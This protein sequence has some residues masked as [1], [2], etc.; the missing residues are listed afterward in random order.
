LGVVLYEMATG[1]MPF[2]GESAAQVITSMMRDKPRRLDGSDPRLPPLL[3]EL[4]ASLL[5]KDPAERPQSAAEVRDTLDRLA[6]RHDSE[7]EALPSAVPRRSWQPAIATAGVDRRRFRSWAIAGAALVAAVVAAGLLGRSLADRAHAIPAV[8][9]LPV[10]SFG[11]EPDYFV[12]GTT[13]GLIGALGRFEGLRV[14]SRQSAMHYKG[15]KMRLPEIADELGVDY[16][17]E[18]SVA[19]D[20]ERLRLQ[21][22]IVRAQ[23]E[24]QVWSQAFE[25]PGSG[26]LA[27]HNEVATAVARALRARVS[28][29][30]EVRM[31]AAREVDPA[32]Y[33]AYL[34]GRQLLEQLR[35]E[36]VRKARE[37]FEEAIRI[38][39]KFALAHSGL[40]DVHWMLAQFFE[41]P[42]IHALLHERS[43]RD[44]LEI[45]P[46]LAAAHAQLGDARSY[47]HWDWSG[48]EAAYRRALELEP[49]SVYAHRKYW[50]L[51]TILGRFD[52][53]RTE[54]ETAVRLD[55]RQPTVELNYGELE[56]IE[57][58]L[59]EARRHFRRALEL[60]P[61][62]PWAYAWLWGVADY[63]NREPERTEA[64]RALLAGIGFPEAVAEM[65]GLPEDASYRD[66]ALR[67]G[68]YLSEVAATRRVPTGTH[69]YLLV[70]AGDLDGAE[71]LML[72]AFE[73]RSPQ[74]LFLAVNPGYV[75]LRERPA[76]RKLIDEMSLPHLPS[77]LR[78]G[79]NE[80]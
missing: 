17:V 67:A 37:Q 76:I 9:V 36:T 45:D 55:P 20:G 5:A 15:S 69:I 25:R 34:R 65:D 19:R 78:R 23:P 32:A 18:A 54:I 77:P 2:P 28:E 44:A 7:T 26:V 63:E 58:N 62:F 41:D 21:A 12:D 53:A 60:D 33:E 1:E 30:E 43:A 48:A 61:Q 14:I 79:S 72:E 35:P 29:S 52:E 57:G 64:L 49:N 3:V 24:Q 71:K 39:P 11:G 47:H 10:V 40:A 68:R 22:Q 31:A 80:D 4:I 59:E 6:R 56:F 16:V 42:S 27:L 75:E 74:V 70:S 46:D 51:L 73:R 8:A 66:K 13:D 50:S 38:D